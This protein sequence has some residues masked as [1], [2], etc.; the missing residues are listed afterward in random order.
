M[1]KPR[2]LV[3]DDDP[4]FLKILQILLPS[5]EMEFCM[6]A[7]GFDA[8]KVWQ[9]EKFDCILL[10]VMMPEINGLDL[11]CRIR[12]LSDVPIILVT[13]L[14]RESEVVSGLE[15][16]ADDYVTKPIRHRELLARIQTQLRKGNKSFSVHQNMLSFEQISLDLAARKVY[17]RGVILPVTPMEYQL[18]EYTMQHRGKVVSKDELLKCVWGYNHSNELARADLNMIEATIRRLRKKLNDHPNHPEYIHTIWG[19][20][21]QFG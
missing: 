13:A 11:C 18:L 10:D 4:E 21:Y 9:I 17:H 3:I 15:A 16:G 2:I 8:W 7:N 5:E 19:I 20:G 14:G 6:L 12:A 1:T